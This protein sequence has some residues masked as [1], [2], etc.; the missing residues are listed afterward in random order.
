[1]TCVS[2]SVVLNTVAPAAFLITTSRLVMSSLP[3]GSVTLARMNTVV[4]TV[5]TPV[6]ALP[7][8]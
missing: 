4:P 1:M 5:G 8:G 2:V 3:N 6:I 7:A